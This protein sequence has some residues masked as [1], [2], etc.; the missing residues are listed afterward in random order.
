MLA[1]IALLATPA[2]AALPKDPLASPMWEF[3]GDQVFGANAV[4]RFDPRVK[5][6]FPTIAE[7]QRVFPV[8]VDARDIPDVVRMVIMVDLNPIQLP[9]DYRLEDADAFVAA[10][11]KLDQRTPVRGAVQLKDGSWLVSGGWIDAAGGG[12]SAPPVSRVKGDWS[13]HLGEVRGGL[14]QQDGA[15][16]LRLAFRHPMDT[17]LV[18][19]IAA[20]YLDELAV[21]SSTGRPLGKL[22][23]QAA[24]A[25]D[26]VISLQPH[27][28]DGESIRFDG[29]DTNGIEF[30]GSVEQVR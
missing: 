11:I 29:R 28:R 4:V 17:G 25:E 5:V 12:C 15:V 2:A 18:D 6:S 9:L 1:P 7:N 20:Y 21:A 26:P 3:V 10:R 27:L 8:Q 13:Q 23:F 22:T 30:R 14:W 16:R 19:N 24:M